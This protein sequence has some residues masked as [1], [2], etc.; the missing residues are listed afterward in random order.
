M[1][2]KIMGMSE[3]ARLLETDPVKAR[4]LA[5]SGF[6]GPFEE[7]TTGRVFV[8]AG[9]VEEA[10]R[11]PHVAPPHPDALVVR[12]A[13]LKEDTD[14]AWPDRRLIGYAT[15]MSDDEVRDAARGWWRVGDPESWHGQLLVATVVGFVVGAWKIR[16]HSN[17][18]GGLRRFDLDE[19]DEANGADRFLNRRL[20]TGSGGNTVHLA[21]QDW[22]LA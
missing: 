15:T 10:A 1:T 14:P 12:L 19:P 21:A 7:T 6:L 16:G 13:G 5:R 11:L 8:D 18:Y 9:R 17:G 3:V 22:S 2:A 20:R 4:Q